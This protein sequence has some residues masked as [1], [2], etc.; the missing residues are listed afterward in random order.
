MIGKSP[1]TVQRLAEAGL[2]RHAMKLP[3]PN[4]AYLFLREDVDRFRGVASQPVDAE[5]GAA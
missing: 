4:G 3:G 5:A 1:R 2:I